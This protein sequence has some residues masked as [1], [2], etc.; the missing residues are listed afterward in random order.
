[1]N[2]FRAAT[3]RLLENGKF[4]D[5]TVMCGNTGKEYKVHRAILSSQSK[6]FDCCCS[7]DCIESQQRFAILREDDPTALEKMI[8]CFY[9]FK[10]SDNISTTVFNSCPVD[11][12][13][14]GNVVDNDEDTGS[15]IKSAIQLHAHVYAIAEKVAQQFSKGRPRM[16]DVHQ[17]EVSDLKGAAQTKF[18]EE[19]AAN[20][21]SVTGMADAINAVYRE[22]AL[23]DSDRALKDLLAIAWVVPGNRRNLQ[24]H[25]EELKDVLEATPQ[26]LFDAQVLLLQGFS[27]STRYPRYFCTE[28]D[29]AAIV[30]DHE[31]ECIWQ[32]SWLECYQCGNHSYPNRI[33]F[34]ENLKIE[35]W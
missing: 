25:T 29:H 4:S 20:M 26:F 30:G 8:E 10:Y 32:N 6:W 23:P 16:V 21:E 9:K 22:I 28:C 2:A 15:I 35:R 33:E 34:S 14:N 17:Y 24:E 11:F 7:R 27:S 3:S 12:D 1:M 31:L 19:L 13:S 18:R 5:F